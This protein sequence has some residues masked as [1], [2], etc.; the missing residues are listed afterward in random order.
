M[1]APGRSRLL[2]RDYALVMV[3]AR[4]C[5]G[6]REFTP[7]LIVTLMVP[8]TERPTPLMLVWMESRAPGALPD[9][10]PTRPQRDLPGLMGTGELLPQGRADHRQL[11]SEPGIRCGSRVE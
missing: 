6:V 9:R 11:F 2:F 1:L 4:I 3:A 7:V 5:R 8:P 10:V